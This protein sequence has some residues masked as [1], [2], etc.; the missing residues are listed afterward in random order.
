MDEHLVLFCFASNRLVSCLPVPPP[1][2]DDEAAARPLPVVHLP[3]HAL[4]AMQ[5]EIRVTRAAHLAS[6]NVH[7]DESDPYA[8]LSHV[9][10]GRALPGA[11][12]RADGP[13]PASTPPRQTAKCGNTLAPRWYQ[14]FFVDGYVPGDALRVEVWDFNKVRQDSVVGVV[15]VDLARALEGTERVLAEHAMGI[16]LPS[17]NLERDSLWS[18][19]SGFAPGARV[20]GASPP[21]DYETGPPSDSGAA[22]YPRYPTKSRTPS[23]PL[24]NAPNAHYSPP[25][26]AAAYGQHPGQNAH[27]LQAP[28]PDYGHQPAQNAQNA[29][30]SPHPPASYGQHPGQ[31]AHHLQAPPP[32]YVHQPGQNA[33]NAHYLPP[34]YGQHPGQNAH[35]PEPPPGYRAYVQHGQQQMPPP[36]Y[37]AY[38]YPQYPGQ[39][40][41]YPPPPY[42]SAPSAPQTHPGYQ[43]PPPVS[44]A[45]HQ[46]PWPNADANAGPPTSSPVRTSVHLQGLLEQAHA[47]SP[48]GEIFLVVVDRARV[49]SL[50]D[51]APSLSF[52]Q[53][54]NNKLGQAVADTGGKQS[55]FGSSSVGRRLF[56]AADHLSS[57]LK[58]VHPALDLALVQPIHRALS[59]HPTWKVD[60]R[61]QTVTNSFAGAPLC[62]WN[63][64]YAAAQKIFSGP[65]ARVVQQA[66]VAQHS[67]LYGGT[68][69]EVRKGLAQTTGELVSGDDFVSV[70]NGGVRN[71]KARMFTYVIMPQRGHHPARLYFAETG[72]KF[73]QDMN[74]KH[75]MHSNAAKE[76]LYAGEFHFR[77]GVAPHEPAVRLVVDNNSGTYAPDKGLLPNVRT[78]L[79]R[80]FEGLCVETL[81]FKDPTLEQY[82]LDVTRS[83][84]ID[85]C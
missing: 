20:S 84:S 32:D 25:P 79:E 7:N 12:R 35:Y 33:Q 21:S 27:H 60:L 22:E 5:L 1:T 36:G 2:A 6:A 43:A 39:G 23:H 28:P 80:N 57:G 82:T 30:Y 29:H 49:S 61:P 38:Q 44:S 78:L 40:Q 48:Q 85:G 76:V 37:A 63:R 4:A 42:A 3:A 66:L 81:D 11:P 13:A 18:R 8:I 45:V 83:V 68:L 74:S 62:G 9:R 15:E 52:Q 56:S 17:P 16:S 67:Y 64:D 41:A 50:S 59:E 65:L 31:N 46:P 24:Q 69:K 14:S 10:A 73:F 71:G 55:H 51:S 58:K 26:A 54:V 75:A 72:A 19:S 34:S 70:V 53:F 47:L 77:K